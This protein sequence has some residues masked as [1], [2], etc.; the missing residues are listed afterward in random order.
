MSDKVREVRLRNWSNRLALELHKTRARRW[1]VNNKL[2][3]RISDATGN[4][5]Y[6]EKFDLTLDDVE[7]YLKTYEAKLK[8]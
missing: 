4:I 2:G 7:N 1:S 3:Y 8:Q 5:L 6:G